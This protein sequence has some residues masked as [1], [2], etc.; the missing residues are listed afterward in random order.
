MC[1]EEK[2]GALQ[3]QLVVPKRDED[4]YF[5]WPKS[6]I[7]SPATVEGDR[8][9]VVTNRGEVVCLDRLGLANGNDGPFKDEGR[10]MTPAELPAIE[11]GPL[12]ADILV[13]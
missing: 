12:D 7:S 3:W 9:Y 5:D 11:P 4:P 10:H 2:T 13:P 1:F 8:V 6:G